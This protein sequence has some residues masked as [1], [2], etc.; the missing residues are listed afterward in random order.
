M[1]KK[2]AAVKGKCLPLLSLFKNYCEYICLNLSKKGRKLQ[3]LP[4]FEALSAV[5]LL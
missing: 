2:H 5:K 4:I 3:T 1:T